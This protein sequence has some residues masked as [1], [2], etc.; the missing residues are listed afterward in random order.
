M[1]C[2]ETSDGRDDH[3]PRKF[4]CDDGGRIRSADR[5]EGL[6]RQVHSPAGTPWRQGWQGARR[7]VGHYADAE[8]RGRH[9]RVQHHRVAR[10]GGSLQSGSAVSP[11]SPG[12]AVQG[13]NV[14]NDR[15]V[16]I[17]PDGN[18]GGNGGSE[19]PGALLPIK[20]G[21]PALR[22]R[23]SALCRPGPIA[24]GLSAG[25][26]SGRFRFVH[27]LS[28]RSPGGTPKPAE[29]PDEYA[30]C[31]WVGRAPGTVPKARP[32]QNVDRRI[33]VG[34]GVVP[35]GPAR[36]HRLRR[37]VYLVGVSADTAGLQCS[38]GRH[39]GAPVLQRHRC[40]AWSP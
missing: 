8:S 31:A 23:Q 19:N 11:G 2:S 10:P 1:K 16:G 37:P 36:E 12:S 27:H 14:G 3:N 33:V 7:L 15:G 28:I 9:G 13:A 18:A 35:A 21:R 24:W 20:Q 40:P 29:Q 17:D 25:T 22:G 26:S 5:H 4:G 38:M 34:V 39:F 30:V 6:S 32:R